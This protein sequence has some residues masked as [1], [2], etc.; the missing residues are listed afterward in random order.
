MCGF[1]F[2]A[3]TSH[4][5]NRHILLYVF[6][7]F[8]II[9]YSIQEVDTIIWVIDGLGWTNTYVDIVVKIQILN[10][11]YLHLLQHVTLHIL[12]EARKILFSKLNKMVVVQEICLIYWGYQKSQ[13]NLTFAFNYSNIS[14]WSKW[15]VMISK[16]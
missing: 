9:S 12:G 15:F 7:M 8:Q 3:L 11:F 6:T 13:H 16:F 5:L 10:F 14:I 2:H 1:L 4:F